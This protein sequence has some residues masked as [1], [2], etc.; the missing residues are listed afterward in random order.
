MDPQRRML[1]NRVLRELLA[2]AEGQHGL[3]RLILGLRSAGIHLAPPQA[4]R[5][6]K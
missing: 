2:W 6:V 3:A 5:R 1:E 4:A